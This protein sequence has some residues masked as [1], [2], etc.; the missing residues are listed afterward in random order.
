MQRIDGFLAEEEVPEWASSLS[1]VVSECGGDCSDVGFDNATFEWH[2]APQ[3]LAAESRFQ[4]GP[5]DIKFPK[6]KLSL[7]SGATGAGKS[8]LLSALL[9]G[10]SIL[11]SN[12]SPLVVFIL[13]MHCLSGVVSINKRGH[14]VA[15]C[16]Q[17]PCK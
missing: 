13:E 15:Y 16:A 7:I 4:L 10:Q 6:G 11:S 5:L 1:T 3:R 17:N 9:G 12:G 8:A 14:Q 2:G